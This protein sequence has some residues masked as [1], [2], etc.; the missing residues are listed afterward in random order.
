MTY[1]PAGTT[2]IPAAAAIPVWVQ[3]ESD[4]LTGPGAVA[5]Q[6]CAPVALFTP[7]TCPFELPVNTMPFDVTGLAAI[8]PSP[9]K[10]QWVGVPLGPTDCSEPLTT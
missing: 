1:P 10:V 7:Y 3:N 9:G 8:A 6:T 5:D 2:S 4:V